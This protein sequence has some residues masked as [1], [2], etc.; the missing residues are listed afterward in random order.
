MIKVN[1]MWKARRKITRSQVCKTIYSLKETIGMCK[2]MLQSIMV[3][4]IMIMSTLSTT[5]TALLSL[6]IS[7]KGFTTM[8]ERYRI[9]DIDKGTLSFIRMTSQ[10]EER[11]LNQ[12]SEI[13]VKKNFL[14]F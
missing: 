9:T 8:T 14:R 10:A 13:T 11:I 1:R 2:E 3:K 12:E 7:S 5:I 6:K 4:I